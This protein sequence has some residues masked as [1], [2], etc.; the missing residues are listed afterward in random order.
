MPS[1]LPELELPWPLALAVLLVTI[2]LAWFL[3]RTYER[4]ARRLTRLR[5]RSLARDLARFLGARL[6]GA[7]LRRT[8]ETANHGTFWSAVE[9]LAF[10]LRRRDWLR[11]SRALERNRHAAAERRALRDDSPWRRELAARRLALLRA[12]SS[13]RALRRAM[14]R[15]PEAV[16][17]AAARALARYGD[18]AA[19]RWV[20]SHPERLA[21]RHPAAWTSLLRAFGRRA[22]A[23]LLAGLDLP[24]ALPALE[25]ALIE[26]LGLLGPAAAAGAIQPRLASPDPELRVAAARALGR[27]AAAERAPALVMALGDGVWQV[28][29]Q[30]AWA[31]GRL[32]APAAIAPLTDC[33]ADPSW[34][35]RRHAAYA[36]GAL[37]A[38]GRAALRHVADTSRDPFARDMALEVLNGGARLRSA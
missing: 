23:D 4:R 32:R 16:R 22:R 18:L 8:V 25:R 17:Y 20:L 11:L 38:D 26:A 12:P 10:R 19:L 14:V 15:G 31:L 28:R 3:A 2:V 35:V 27:L 5:S 36:L 7:T 37:G 9:P 34:W 6:R 33:L 24:P 30:A 21:S 29:A 13:R 1:A